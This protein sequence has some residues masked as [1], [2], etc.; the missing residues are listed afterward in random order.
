MFTPIEKFEERITELFEAAQSLSISS[1]DFAQPVV[2]HTPAPSLT[3]NYSQYP[4]Q[5]AP[6]VYTPLYAAQQPN[7]VITPAQPISFG[8]PAPAPSYQPM[9]AVKDK[10]GITESPRPAAPKPAEMPAPAPTEPVIP[11]EPAEEQKT[12]KK[13]KGWWIF[14]KKNEEEDDA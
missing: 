4:A 1:S 9:Y 7:S 2:P 14:G 3:P 10:P 6:Q 11:E 8:A 5:Q 13:K 12:E